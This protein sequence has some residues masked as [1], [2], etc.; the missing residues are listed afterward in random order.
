VYEKEKQMKA[1]LA[2]VLLGVLVSAANAQYPGVLFL[3]ETDLTL[4]IDYLQVTFYQP[5]SLT[6]IPDPPF[7]VSFGSSPSVAWEVFGDWDSAGRLVGWATGAASTVQSVT[8]FPNNIQPHI[9]ARIQGYSGPA[10]VWD[11]YATRNNQWTYQLEIMHWWDAQ[12][13]WMEYG[14]DEQEN[15]EVGV[16]VEDANSL[17]FLNTPIARIVAPPVP[18]PALVQMAALTGLG[19]LGLLRLRR[20]A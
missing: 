3:R 11:Y 18:E 17:R 12:F 7:S 20:K 13:G 2:V 8:F 19:A 5:S 16:P 1:I 10:L 4:T 9:L 6:E 15:R 14:W